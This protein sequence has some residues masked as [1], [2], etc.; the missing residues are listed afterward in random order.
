VLRLPP[1]AP[2]EQ[3]I[4]EAQARQRRQPPTEGS[5]IVKR[6]PRALGP[7]GPPASARPP[8]Q[9][10]R[11]LLELPLDTSEDDVFNAAADVLTPLMEEAELKRTRAELA[12]LDERRD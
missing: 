5:G 3:I 6:D 2:R 12:A 11:E 7:S 4:R 1:E 9:K 10:L 8:L